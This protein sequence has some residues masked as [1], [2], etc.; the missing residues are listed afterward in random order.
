MGRKLQRLVRGLMRAARSASDAVSGLPWRRMG[1]QVRLAF[2]VGHRAATALFRKD[3][4]ALRRLRRRL[5]SG[6]ISDELGDPIRKVSLAAALLTALSGPAVF[7]VLGYQ[8]LVTSIDVK[9]QMLADGLSRNVTERVSSFAET[10]EAL[11]AAAAL[12][13]TWDETLRQRIRSADG[14]V[15][16][17]YGVENTG[18]T[19]A[20][21]APIVIGDKTIG[22]IQVSASL[23]PLLSQTGLVAAV[24]ALLGLL[25]FGAAC[26]LPLRMLNRA[27]G[28]LDRQRHKL[29]NQNLLF[30]SAVSNMSQGLCMFDADRRLA[31]CNERWIDM[32]GLSREE[33]RSGVSFESVLRARIAYGAY[34]GPDPE[35]YI[36]ERMAA[37]TSGKPTTTIQEMRDGRYIVIRHQ[38]LPDGGWVATHEDI[39]EQR[40]IEA[41]VAHLAHHDALTN[42]PNRTLLLQRIDEAAARVR[43]G[44]QFAVLCLDLDRF[45]SINDTLGH[46]VGDDL[47]VQVAQRI[48][49]ALRET[50]TVA[51]LGGDEFAIV[52]HGTDFPAE[53]A[54]LA[55][56]VCRTLNEPFDLDNRQLRIACSIGITV[57]P[58]DGSDADQL[59]RNADIAL[60][61][62]KSDGRGIFRFFEPDM[63][64]QQKARRA[65]ELD[66]G[67]ALARDQFALHYQPIVDLNSRE[68]VGFEALLRWHHPERGRV[69]PD[70]FIPVVEETGQIIPIGEWVLRQACRQAAKWPGR[71][72][73][74]VNLSSV[75]FRIGNI[76]QLVTETLDETGLAP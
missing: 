57:A 44:G 45:K 43:R 70:L 41:K 3:G 68:I 36:R 50:D 46:P 67:N 62:A 33:T 58:K 48:G 74:S 54:E 63:D 12:A 24:G 32:Y 6:R 35:G 30:S 52:M 20:S 38:P 55:K 4:E 72:R 73:M 11:S 31:V 15:V 34:S 61:R 10:G 26:L 65:L 42:L 1:Q 40:R 29:R 76:V 2:L 47:L 9:A 53:A 51:R 71:Y 69:P 64:A 22:S 13:V 17:E 37:V 60:Y 28:D 19:V 59:L 18:P 27:V 8:A 56:R 23:S 25:V 5:S 49:S 75:Q 39:T 14:K 7:A 66:L 16:L 21:T